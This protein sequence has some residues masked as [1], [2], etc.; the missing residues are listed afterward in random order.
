MYIC[1]TADRTAASRLAISAAD[2]ADPLPA[3]EL[4]TAFADVEVGRVAVAAGCPL[5]SACI[6][7]CKQAPCH[8]LWHRGQQQHCCQAGSRVHHLVHTLPAAGVCLS[9]LQHRGDPI[10][11]VQLQVVLASLRLYMDDLYARTMLPSS[12]HR[13]PLLQR[14]G[15]AVVLLVFGLGVHRS[16]AKVAVHTR[17][18]SPFTLL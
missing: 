18:F 8:A 3:G 4:V 17:L 6:L 12:E 2:H 11:V 14:T 5:R 10:A 1:S 15:Y 9:L 7:A 13:Y 16:Y